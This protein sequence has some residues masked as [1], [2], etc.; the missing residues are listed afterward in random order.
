MKKTGYKFSI[1][2]GSLVLV[3]AFQNCSKSSYQFME[4]GSSPIGLNTSA[5]QP[6]QVIG[7]EGHSETPTQVPA[8]SQTS[9]GLEIPVGYECTSISD[10]NFTRVVD[11][12]S[13][14]IVIYEKPESACMEVVCNEEQHAN[15]LQRKSVVLS[16]ECASKL[17]GEKTYKIAF[18]DEKRVSQWYLNASDYKFSP[19]LKNFIPLNSDRKLKFSLNVIYANSPLNAVSGTH[20]VDTASCDSIEGL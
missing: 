12:S 16:K 7:G 13:T 5:G 15:I 11:G 10:R 6:A 2:L 19:A 17:S 3:V 20:L 4:P 1:A 18:V 9:S 14:R 8:V